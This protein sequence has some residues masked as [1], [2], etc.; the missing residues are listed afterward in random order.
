LAN[1]PIWIRCTCDLVRGVT[2]IIK[3]IIAN[4][5]GAMQRLLSSKTALLH[6]KLERTIYLPR[7]VMEYNRIHFW[8]E[9]PIFVMLDEFQ[10]VL[11][12]N[13]SDGKPADTVGLYQWAVEGRKCP[14]IITG[15]AVR[16]I[17]QEVRKRGARL[18]SQYDLN[19]VKRP[20]EQVQRELLQKYKKLKRKYSEL[21]GALV[22]AL[23]SALLNRF[24][25]RQ[26]PGRLFRSCG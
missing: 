9:T 6:H 10:D 4:Y 12:I 25:D 11:R 5:A 24:D 22:E 8:P 26:V 18:G 2:W 3:S 17:T 23:L 20:W 14:H 21:V 15:S 1:S 7:R 16:L 19:I 13:Y